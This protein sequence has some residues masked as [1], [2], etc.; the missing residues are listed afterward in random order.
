MHWNDE[1]IRN[2]FNRL[3]K[4]TIKLANQLKMAANRRRNT[5]QILGS[6][7]LLN[8]SSDKRFLGVFWVA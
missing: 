4:W 7:I 5:N 3:R 6:R 8:V 2:W 1:S